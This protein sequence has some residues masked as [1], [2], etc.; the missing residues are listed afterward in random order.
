MVVGLWFGALGTHGCGRISEPST[1]S[2]S[3]FLHY[4]LDRCEDGLECIS[5]LCTQACT[6]GRDA[7][8][9]LLNESSVCTNQ[10]V[11][12]GTL[13]VCDVGCQTE[14]ECASLGR[15]HACDDGF[16]RAPLVD[17]VGG[18]G[19]GGGSSV[20]GSSSS[21]GSSAGAGGSGVG[22][23]R[24]A[25]GG[26]SSTGGASPSESG[27]APGVGGRTPSGEPDGFLCDTDPCEPSEICTACRLG[28]VTFDYR[29]TP[30]PVKDPSGFAASTEDCDEATPMSSCDGPEDCPAGDVCQPDTKLEYADVSCSTPS[31]ACAPYAYCRSCHTD[32][33]CEE[34]FQCLARDLSDPSRGTACGDELSMLLA[35][36]DWLIGWSG[37]AEHFN[38]FHFSPGAAKLTEGTVQV[39]AANCS[40][41]SDW[42]CHDDAG[43][44]TV[45]SDNQVTLEFP[46]CDPVTIAFRLLGQSTFVRA[47]PVRIQGIVE[48][49]TSGTGLA[50]SMYD[51]GFA[52]ELDFT[53]CVYPPPR[54]L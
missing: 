29:C 38:W 7:P 17:A 20:G 53:S 24:P 12:P 54:N 13:A 48:D 30:H 35:R 49:V 33:D 1:G 42:I 45:D 10:S 11:E 28:T 34:G 18:A 5:G 46:S 31:E 27:G 23:A 43:T 37:G 2:E 36:G 44:Y 52:C 19:A 3:H 41:C 8:C 14:R 21:G 25:S 40:A 39:Q 51:R 32:D 16:C 50:A 26:V 4:C 15:L 9:Q 6:V 22:G 47:L